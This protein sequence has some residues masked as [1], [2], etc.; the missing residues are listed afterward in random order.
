MS[1]DVA[2]RG[3][4][5]IQV[6]FSNNEPTAGSDFALFVEVTN[7]FDVPIWPQP[8][9]V[10]FPN[11][12]TPVEIGQKMALDSLLEELSR[13]NSGP[14]K[15]WLR[16]IW[17]LFMGDPDGR[18][19]KRAMAHL[20]KR[21]IDVDTKIIDLETAQEHARQ[22]L[23]DLMRELSPDDRVDMFENNDRV[24][25]LNDEYTKLEDEIE[26]LRDHLHDLRGSIAMLTESTIL[27]SDEGVNLRNAVIGYGGVYISS[28]GPLDVSSSQEMATPMTSSL[29]VGSPVQPGETVVYKL[30][31]NTIKKTMFK[32]IQ[33]LLSFNINY[34]FDE[35]LTELHTDTFAQ[36]LSIRAP[37]ISIIVGAALGSFGGFLAKVLTDPKENPFDVANLPTNGANLLVTMILS[38]MSVVFL[39][40]KGQASTPVSVEDF[41]GGMVLGFLVGYTGSSVFDK[42]SETGDN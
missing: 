7:P 13:E 9:R 40:K 10:F 19:M 6:R 11:E 16:R 20:A 4:L 26:G 18:E 36:S 15:G 8:P 14:G 25:A 23:S 41:W 31:L 17:D 3:K 30:A 27:V 1:K 22:Q 34:G 39:A 32:P 37:I 28:A 24:K 21:V 33:Y 29:P 2:Q 38:A 5:S 12:L 42:F 35:S